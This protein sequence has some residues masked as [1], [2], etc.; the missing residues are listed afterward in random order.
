MGAELAVAVPYAAP[1][2]Q[3]RRGRVAV[4]LLFAV[5]GVI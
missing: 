4:N 3:A 2:A 5:H 1:G